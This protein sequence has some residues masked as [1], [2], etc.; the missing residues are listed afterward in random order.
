MFGERKDF[1]VIEAVK[2]TGIYVQ[3]TGRDELRLAVI[4]VPA[5]VEYPLY[6]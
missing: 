5:E 4:E 6:G 3:A 2:T 1:S